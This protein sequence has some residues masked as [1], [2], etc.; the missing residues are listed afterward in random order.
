MTPREFFETMQDE[1]SKV[2]GLGAVY[3]FKITGEN[4][5][6][7]YLD[8]TGDEPVVAEGI[9]D[10]PGAT[11]TAL[12]KDFVD[13][14][15]GKLASQMAFMMGKLKVSGDMMLAMRLQAIFP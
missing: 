2:K 15:T 11:F 10:S 4:G 7:W 5:G 14:A 3:Q 1:L 6:N 13:M 12:D 9:H 8:A